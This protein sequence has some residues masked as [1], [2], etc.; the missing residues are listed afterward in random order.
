MQNSRMQNEGG[1]PNGEITKQ[2]LLVLSMK[3]F[4]EEMSMRFFLNDRTYVQGCRIHACIGNGVCHQPLCAKDNCRKIR[5]AHCFKYISLVPQNHDFR[6]GQRQIDWSIAN[7]LILLGH[8]LLTWHNKE[9]SWKE[10]QDCLMLIYIA[11]LD[12]ASCC[13]LRSSINLFMLTMSPYKAINVGRHKARP[14]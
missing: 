12:P 9:A 5:Q 14:V 13:Q 4:Q 6:K 7:A 2:S 10:Q 1:Y 11:P 8:M 3:A